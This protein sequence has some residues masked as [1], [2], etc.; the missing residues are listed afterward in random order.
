MGVDL[1]ERV[2]CLGV[3]GWRQPVDLTPAVGAVFVSPGDGV[4][5]A[6][7]RR[8]DLSTQLGADA[9][10]TPDGWGCMNYLD[11]RRCARFVDALAQ[12][13]WVGTQLGH[14]PDEVAGRVQHELQAGP[15]Q[16]GV[17]SV[18][19]QLRTAQ[20][21]PDSPYAVASLTPPAA[22]PSAPSVTV[23][24]PEPPRPA[25]PAGAGV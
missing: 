3:T 10:T 21:A 1:G 9:D 7:A 23:S 22:T 11:Q 6:V 2:A 17:R 25:G 15:V 14:G 20:F 12:A 8:A 16:S 4:V 19:A 24:Q 5:V 13:A 18:L